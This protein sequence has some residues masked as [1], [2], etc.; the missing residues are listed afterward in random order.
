MGVPFRSCAVAFIYVQQL[1]E[2]RTNINTH[3]LTH[4]IAKMRCIFRSAA[5]RNMHLAA[6]PVRYSLR[7]LAGMLRTLE[8]GAVVSYRTGSHH[9]CSAW[10]APTYEFVALLTS[11]SCHYKKV[12]LVIKF[13]FEGHNPI[14]AIYNSFQGPYMAL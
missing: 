14:I 10:E 13:R 1:G 12:S 2:A 5:V 7:L 9:V 6:D 11:G 3:T 8:A 4:A